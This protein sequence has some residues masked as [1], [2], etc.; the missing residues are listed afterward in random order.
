MKSNQNKQF[1]IGIVGCGTI[2]NV[3]AE[4][5]RQLPN[6]ELISVYSRNIDNALRLGQKFN[7]TASNKWDEFIG[8]E[9]L[10]VVT[11]CTPNGTHL[12][13]GQRIAEAGKHIVVEKPIEVTLERGKQLIEACEQHNVRLAVIFQNRFLPE[14][15]RMKD[16]IDADK[17][18]KI[19]LGDAYIK[20]HRTQ[21]YYDS[22]QWR[23]TF[24]L[25]G[26][27]VLINQAI[28]TIDL[29]LWMLGKVETV[30]GHIGTFTH[31]GI[32]GEDAAV[33]TLHFQNGAL[34]VIEASTSVQPAMERRLEIHGEKG[35]AILS[36]NSF[37][38]LGS[39]FSQ[40][41]N[42]SP[43]ETSASGASSPLQNFTAEPHRRQ[44]EAILNTISQNQTPPVSGEESLESLAIV[45]G[46]YQSAKRDCP[47][48]L[49]TFM[50][51]RLG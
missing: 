5:I 16:A 11:V 32:E 38:L 51:E 3:H 18:G 21:A 22:A 10:D 35:T 25:D 26:G 33:A 7:V 49:P 36:G 43:K 45:L 28:H 15:I 4:A 27:G 12:D 42:V 9:R 20:W 24:A 19:F 2:A 29:L 8:D 40:Q 39:G 30:F 14:V 47:I 41:E 23:G 50:K 34:G 48:N 1:G 17:L 44:Y 46:I 6:A 31:T 13:Y 37:H